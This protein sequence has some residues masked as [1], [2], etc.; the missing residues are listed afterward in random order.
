MK[1][2]IKKGNGK[3]VEEGGGWNKEFPGGKENREIERSRKTDMKS[4]KKAPVN[5]LEL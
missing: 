4:E 2:E 1:V 5:T 3:E